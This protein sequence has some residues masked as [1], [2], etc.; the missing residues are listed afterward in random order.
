LCVFVCWTAEI[1]WIPSVTPKA[2]DSDS[3]EDINL[4]TKF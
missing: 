2:S 1:C 3:L 4:N